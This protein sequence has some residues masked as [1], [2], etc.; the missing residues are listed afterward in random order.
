[1]PHRSQPL[2]PPTSSISPA[3]T[4]SH[5]SNGRTTGLLPSVNSVL[6]GSAQNVECDVTH[7]KQTI[8]EFLPGS[9]IGQCRA[10]TS[11]AKPL[12]NR[13]RE[14]LESSLTHRKQTV[15]SRSNRELS[16]NPCR[17]ISRVVIPIP[18]FLTETASQ[19]EFTVTHSK[20]SV[21]EILTGAR[22]AHYGFRTAG[23]S[24]ALLDLDFAP[25]LAVSFRPT[26]NAAASALIPSLRV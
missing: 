5:D 23:V 6:P 9:R 20:Q 19:T 8:G 15:A 4:K 11:I 14:L 26:Q 17:L 1:V 12:S 24:P 13:D 18:T 22:I 7:S 25:S 21:G 16:T 2:N 10:Q 3:A